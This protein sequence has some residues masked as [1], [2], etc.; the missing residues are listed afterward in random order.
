M[1]SLRARALSS[2]LAAQNPDGGWSY[3][4]GGSWTEPTA[5]ALLALSG[6]AAAIGHRERGVRYLAA[7]QRPEGGWPPR[8]S[9]DRSTWVTSLVLLA[10]RDR[11]SRAARE[12]AVEW[13]LGQSGEETRF[14][15]RLRMR[16]LGLGGDE[17]EGEG[18]PWFPE[19]AAWVSPTA[20][21]ILALEKIDA[22]AV[23]ARLSMARNFLWSRRCRD[24]GW[25]HGSTRALGYDAGSYPETTGQALLAMHGERSPKLPLALTAAQRH[26]RA[27]RSS[28]AMSWLRLGL[29]AHAWPAPAADLPHRGTMDTALWLIAEQ[30]ASGSN[31]F[32][33]ES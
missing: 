17:R 4:G 29:L 27:C 5:L 25:N 23:G 3:R 22:K 7:L 13:L 16:L 1:E 14:F 33:G 26:L 19:T 32:L 28:S 9:V 6:E 15:H 2:L 21:T 24:G 30:A 20:L 18:W 11:L 31:A 10:L 8:P 12:R